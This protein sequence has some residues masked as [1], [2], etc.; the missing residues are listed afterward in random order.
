MPFRFSIPQRWLIYLFSALIVLLA[1]IT[2]IG[3]RGV[4]HLWR[5]RGEKN[6]LDEQNFRLQKENEALR[7][8]IYRIRNDNAYLEKLAR[9]ELNLVR[10]GEIVYRF[11]NP[12]NRPANQK[13]ESRPN[14][15]PRGAPGG[16]PK[17]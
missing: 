13:P 9:E 6:R 7:Q 15:K 3:E 16:K 11:S 4:L 10:P 12:A 5:L 17:P 2:V 14:T 8:R 1:L